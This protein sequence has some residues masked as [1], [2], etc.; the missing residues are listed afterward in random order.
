GWWAWRRRADRGAVRGQDGRS[1][2]RGDAEARGVGRPLLAEGAA[3]PGRDVRPPSV[4]GAGGRVSRNA[5][6]R[7]RAMLK[8]HSRLFEHIV[9]ATDLALIGACWVAAYFLRFYVVGPAL[10]TRVVPPRGA[11]LLQLSPL[12]VVWGFSFPWS[13]L[14]RPRR[15]GSHLAEWVDVAKA[16]SLGALVIV[17]IM[18]FV[19]KGHEYSRV[20]IL[21]F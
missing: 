11:S 12:V 2:G 4:Q 14:S 16:S 13:D 15:L 5:A 1:T 6:R 17:A 3:R 8:A 20:V 7:A 18:A 21:Y 19:F 10:V 9:L